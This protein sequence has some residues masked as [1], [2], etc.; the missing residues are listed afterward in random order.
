MDALEEDDAG[1]YEAGH[2][3]KF[4]M[5]TRFVSMIFVSSDTTDIRLFSSAWTQKGPR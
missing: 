5:L 1:G 2:S 4:N 3:L